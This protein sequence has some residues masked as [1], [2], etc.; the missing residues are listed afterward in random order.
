MRPRIKE[1]GEF[2][3]IKSI[4]VPILFLTETELHPNIN[5]DVFSNYLEIQLYIKFPVWQSRW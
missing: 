4:A 5:W 2:F 1:L 3:A